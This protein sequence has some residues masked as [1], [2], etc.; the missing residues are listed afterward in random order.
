M[1][2]YFKINFDLLELLP[3]SSSAVEVPPTVFIEVPV[4]DFHE[5]P[6][7]VFELV[8]DFQHQVPLRIS[9]LKFYIFSDSLIQESSSCPVVFLFRCVHKQQPQIQR[10]EIQ[11]LPMGIH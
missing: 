5:N 9:S 7:L 6:Q 2:L 4:W 8:D 10:Q 1:F 11:K 3:S